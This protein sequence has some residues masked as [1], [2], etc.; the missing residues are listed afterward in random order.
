MMTD[1]TTT[2]FKPLLDEMTSRIVREFS[3]LKVILFGSRARRKSHRW[4][5]VDLLVVMPDG[6]DR[7]AIAVEIR[8]QL[9]D[10]PVSKDIVVT[11]PDEISRRGNLVGT[12][13]REALRDGEVLHERR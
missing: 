13:L 2:A 5:D 9:A 7:R 8:R 1:A 10:L 11:T 4:S 6:S 3:P 12:V